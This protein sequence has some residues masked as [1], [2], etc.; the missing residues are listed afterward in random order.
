MVF[1]F[2]NQATTKG[3]INVCKLSTSQYSNT[4]ILQIKIMEDCILLQSLTTAWAVVWVF[5]L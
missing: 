4:N 3:T 2:P 1:L 5:Y